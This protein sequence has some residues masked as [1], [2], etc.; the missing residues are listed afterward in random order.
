[1]KKIVLYTERYWRDVVQGRRR[2][3]LP[4]LLRFFLLPFSWIYRLVTWIRNVF[5]QKRWFRTYNPPVD[6]VISIG[7]IVV[8]G[9]GKTPFTLLLAESLYMHHRLGILY[10][11]YR[12]KAEKLSTPMTL[13]RGNGPM[14]SAAYCGDEAYLLA[15]NIPKAH[16]FV[17]KNR[18]I[19]ARLAAD[20]GVQCLIMDDGLQHRRI[21][22][23]FDIVL[24]DHDDPFGQGYFLPRGLLR[25][26]S[27]ALQRAHLIVVYPVRKHQDFLSLRDRLQKSTSAPI[28]GAKM[29]I[30]AVRTQSG[31][32]IGSLIGKKVGM[33]CGI[34][35]PKRFRQTLEEELGATI[36]SEAVLPDH[37]GMQKE[38]FIHFIE[39]T[40]EQ[41]GE[42]IVCTEKDCVK[43][44]DEEYPLPIFWVQVKMCIT[45]EKEHWEA[46][47]S[48]VHN[49]INK[50]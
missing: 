18:R 43:L 19:G 36:V 11:G 45:E 13:C 1:M 38:D 31:E 3:I 10:R 30:V 15:K 42:A 23:D 22:R 12:S 29:E 35:Q 26:D 33:L 39:E 44:V 8:G 40:M 50:R 24:I 27:S 47:L 9:T 2:G 14:F 6:A 34:A 16:I 4:I 48:Q 28:I 32:D 37:M 41:G 49:R 7:N 25:E 17:G 46:F 5:Y 20:C 21:A